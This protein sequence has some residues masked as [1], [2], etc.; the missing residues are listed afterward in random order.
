MQYSS[1]Y[2]PANYYRACSLQIDL[3]TRLKALHDHRTGPLSEKNGLNM[4]LFLDSASA[5]DAR[6][7]FAYDFVGGITTNP[8]L[9]AKI[10]RPAEEVI[11]ELCEIA[12]GT[13]FYQ[14][15]ADDPSARKSE[16]ERMLNLIPGR[17]GL[18]IPCTRENLQLAAEF[19]A[20]G[21]VVGV[22][23]I[24][25]PAQVYLACEAG[26]RYVL[27]YV[28]RSTRLLGDGPGLVRQMRAVIDALGS[29]L[30]I[31]AASVKTPQEAV[32]TV[33][34]GAHHLTLPLAVIDAMAQH[35]LSDEA[36]EAFARAGK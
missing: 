5:R 3:D 33:L 2:H 23:A 25:S 4:T 9:L 16:G 18:K 8:S 17:V 13:V 31:I 35:D 21:H 6:S 36:I 19:A 11:A 22:T 30:E 1:L 26:A 15:Q 7:A 12:K 34:A 28:N 20:R 29:P 32:D 24:F 27:P 10:N 14:L